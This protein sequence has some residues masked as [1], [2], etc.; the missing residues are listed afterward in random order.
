MSQGRWSRPLLA[1]L[2]LAALPT[3]GLAQAEWEYTP[4]RV[5]LWIAVAGRTQLPPPVRHDLTTR[6]AARAET[7]FGAAWDARVEAPPAEL[8]ER[9]VA[10]LDLPIKQLQAVAPD[11]LKGDKLI[12]VRL[13]KSEVG[14]DVESRELDCRTR[15]WGPVARRS[16]DS[17]AELLF[18]TWD[19]AVAAFTPLARIERVEHPQ[20][21]ARLRA[22]G[23]IVDP[24]SPALVGQ[25]SVL[26]AVIRRNDR[27]GEPAARGGIL[28]VPWT[29]LS[30]ERRDDAMLTCQTHSGFRAA[31]PT[32]GGIR[33]ERL[34]LVVRPRFET[35]TLTLR[36]RSAE[37]RPLAGYEIFSKAPGDEEPRRLGTSDWRGEIELP[38]DDGSIRLL[39][40]RNGTQ[41]IAR[42]PIVPGHE[43]RVDAQLVDDDGRLQVEG[44][45]AALHSRALDLVAR[46]EI[47]AA[48]FRAR[49]KEQK[50]DEAQKML[51]DFRRL[52]SRA[53]LG[54]TLDEQ[55]QLV[56]G[57]EKLTQQRIDKL[58]GEARRLLTVKGLADDMVNTLS[59]ELVRARSGPKTAAT[60][61]AG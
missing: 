39:L 41:L 13:T 7:V 11:V 23:L 42:L 1:A 32:R 15:L 8:G 27:T 12:A 59:A 52:D 47:L 29:L 6:I 28:Q 37:P 54:R 49:L 31:I 10:D 38:R 2:L 3:S 19:A 45:V 5:R 26:R 30:V 58:F 50:F 33:I 53:D 60:G 57:S 9:L 61:K 14:W 25:G 40:V 20:V 48:R 16:A 56:Q 43:P 4:Y 17:P 46:R 51:D 35:T 22:G 24:S 18:A 55:Q 36:S 44:A 34:A 21:Q